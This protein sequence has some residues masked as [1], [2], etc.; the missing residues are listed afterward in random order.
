MPL[1]PHLPADTPPDFDA[2]LPFELALTRIVE[3]G[4]TPGDCY[5]TPD[6]AGF[7]PADSGT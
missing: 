2:L 7:R 5:K 1:P 6:R 3:D 4:Y